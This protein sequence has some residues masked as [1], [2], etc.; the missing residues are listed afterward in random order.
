M[1][2]WRWPDLGFRPVFFPASAFVLGA[3][4]GPETGLAGAL[5]LILTGASWAAT[6]L[7]GRRIGAHALLLFAFFASGGTLALLSMQTLVPAGVEDG[8]VVLEG[9]LERVDRRESFTQVQLRV[10]RTGEPLTEA[11]F[12][13]RLSTNGSLPGVEPGQ[14]V[15]V[16]AKLKA[17]SGP[18]NPGEW[19]GTRL[20]ERRGLYFTGGL[21]EGS[22]LPLSPA[23][24]WRL[25]VRAQHEAMSRKVETL[26]PTAAGAAL[27]LTL[28]AG[29]RAKLDD[30]LEEAFGDSGLSHILSVSGLH[31]AALALL[32]LR[33][34]RALLV[35]FA[36]ISVT[37]EAR[38]LAA[39]I[40]VP[41]IWAYVAF[42]GMQVPAVRSAVMASVVFVGLA[43]WRRADA[44]NALSVAAAAIVA[45]DP[46][47]VMDLSLQLSFVAVLSLILVSPALRAVIPLERPTADAPWRLRARETCIE[48]MCAGIAVTLASAPLLAGSFGRVSVVGVLANIVCLPLSGLLTVLAAG[49][50]ALFV[51]S[52]LLS[53]P[54][55]WLGSLSSELLV[56][57][58]R[59]FAAVPGAALAVRPLGP[60]LGLLSL[61]GLFC[62]ALAQRRWRWAGIALPLVLLVTAAVLPSRVSPGLVVTFLAVG[63]GDG[64]V[65]SSGG[66]HALI[67]GGGVPNGGDTGRRYVLP[68]LKREGIDSLELAVLSHPHPDHA[69][70]LATTLE[71]VPTERLWLAAGTTRGALSRKVRAAARSRRGT[72]AILREVDASA[73]FFT[74]GEARIEVLGPPEDRLL[75]EGV[76][77]RSVVLR[78]EHGDVSFLLP[79]DIE[80]TAEEGLTPYLRPVT[81]LKAPH[82]GS[83]TSS[84]AEFVRRT[85]PKHVVFCVGRNNRFGF[86]HR[87][88]LERYSAR[89]ARCHRTDVSGAIRIESDGRDVRLV[90]FHAPEEQQRRRAVA[91]RAS[92]RHLPSR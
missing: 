29:L 31:V 74:L 87:E 90:P 46:S 56:L 35:R 34:L 20:R 88:V 89:G 28:S 79:G 7:W 42:T 23:P 84:T 39:P 37:L 49:G 60:A 15:R 81:V 77:D 40:A 68:F 32:L 62:F 21:L 64:I 1:D 52:P 25:W 9:L 54:V 6:G 11:R 41:L 19:D 17:I 73:P 36:P 30:S 18:D 50:A 48:A 67:D 85:R 8:P 45:V 24:A 65:L 92:R 53:T 71:K 47:S 12:R 82:H 44:L 76:N 27:Y 57:V 38:R 86:P 55:L 75:L 5:F 26:A 22:L 51:L 16:R 91:R 14:W 4:V 78:V 70:G 61:L 83:R 72:P 10:V 69:L 66:A 63:Q 13:A 80:E 3:A 43:L 59:G 33:L 2:G 58:A